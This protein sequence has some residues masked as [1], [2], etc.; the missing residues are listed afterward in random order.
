MFS[1][2]LA[3]AKE[4]DLESLAL[5]DNAALNQILTEAEERIQKTGG[6]KHDDFWRSLKS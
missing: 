5:S 1:G 6:I 3:R 2:I 4:S